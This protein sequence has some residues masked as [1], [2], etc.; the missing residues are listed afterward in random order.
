[1]YIFVQHKTDVLWKNGETYLCV[2]MCY[3]Y[4]DK[5]KKK[6]NEKSRTHSRAHKFTKNISTQ[7]FFIHKI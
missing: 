1:M 7:T 3:V 2:C 5:R 4:R 6:E